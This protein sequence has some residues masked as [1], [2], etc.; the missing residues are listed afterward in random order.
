MTTRRLAWRILLGFGLGF[1]VL[2][3]LSHAAAKSARARITEF[4][5]PTDCGLSEDG[6]CTPEAIVRGLDGAL[7]FAEYDGKQIGR[8]SVTGE[9]QEFPVPA[10]PMQLVFDA[11][12]NLWFTDANKYIGKLNPAGETTLFEVP[13][14]NATP[15]GIVVGP[16]QNIWFTEQSGNAI[17]KVT[18]DGHITEYPLATPG[19]GPISIAVGLDSNLW[20]TMYYT[21]KIGKI[22]PQGE[23]T[24]YPIPQSDEGQC[25]T[26]CFPDSIVRDFQDKLWFAETGRNW[27]SNIN[28]NGEFQQYDL[29]ASAV[30]PNGMSLTLGPG[31]YI[32]FVDENQR[33]GKI[34]A[35]GKF[36]SYPLV[37][38]CDHAQCGMGDIVFGPDNNLWFTEWYGNQIGR[39]NCV[40]RL[41]TPKKGA[42]LH[43]KMVEFRWAKSL[44][45]TDGY[46]IQ[47][48]EGSTEG[49]V[50]A[51]AKYLKKN[52]WSADLPGGH[53]YFWSVSACGWTCASKMHTF[54]LP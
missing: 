48:R 18:P 4:P 27:V 32:W 15:F 52:K 30:Y 39:L 14:P 8:I 24:E 23:I 53:K 42:V 50:V 35:A 54:S 28:A 11:D 47:V 36:K 22:T 9:I 40:P 1:L 26:S 2:G 16:D 49:A 5:L 33:I 21:S 43:S 41:Q 20:F 46:A 25:G 31:G 44:C 19:N 51:S 29:G 3:T 7:W 17:G 10:T 38:D 13:T 37:L 34:D 45:A 6:G 12:G